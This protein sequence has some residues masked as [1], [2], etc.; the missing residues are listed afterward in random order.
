MLFVTMISFMC[1]GLLVKADRLRDD[2]IA[3]EESGIGYIYTTYEEYNVTVVRKRPE[4]Q[5]GAIRFSNCRCMRNDPDVFFNC[6]VNPHC[7][8]DY[9][10]LYNSTTCN[11]DAKATFEKLFEEFKK[12][13]VLIWKK[14]FL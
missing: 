11:D 8:S 2:G 12:K 1:F 7:R 14:L 5:I 10:F 4:Q 6:S 3:L 13:G 9:E